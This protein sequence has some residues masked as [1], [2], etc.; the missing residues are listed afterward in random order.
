LLGIMQVPIGVDW[1]EEL[2]VAWFEELLIC[3]LL[4]CKFELEEL[5]SKFDDFV[6]KSMFNFRS[7]GLNLC[8][9]TEVLFFARRVR[10]CTVDM[11]K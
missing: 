2:L 9:I 7:F 3:E 8:L 1:F 10:P 4:V 5:F 11:L 6:V